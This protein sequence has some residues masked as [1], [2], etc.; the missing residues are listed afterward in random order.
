MPDGTTTARCSGPEQLCE[1]K[2]SPSSPGS[3]C[4]TYDGGEDVVQ[5]GL[6]EG[7]EDLNNTVP[8]MDPNGTHGC[9][10]TYGK[11][12]LVYLDSLVGIEEQKCNGGQPCTD[13][14]DFRRNC[15]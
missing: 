14:L 6:C 3:Q 12:T 2:G 4:L 5:G 15:D 11:A 10:Y 8:T 13:W 1:A 7:G 9:T